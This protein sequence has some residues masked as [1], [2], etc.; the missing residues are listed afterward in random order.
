MSLEKRAIMDRLK[1]QGTTQPT[2][3]FIAM[4]MR[5]GHWVVKSQKK[6]KERQ[7]KEGEVGASRRRGQCG[8]HDSCLPLSTRVAGGVSQVSLSTSCLLGQTLPEACKGKEG[9]AHHCV[10]GPV[11]F[12]EEGSGS[13]GL[14]REMAPRRTA[15]RQL[16]GLIQVFDTPSIPNCWHF[17]AF[18][19][20]HL[21]SGSLADTDWTS[22]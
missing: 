11:T 22:A 14:N 3:P 8:R 12:E 20:P 15:G 10:A 16:L 2:S 6:G 19:L 1:I 9:L 5:G 4:E 13:L 21:S 18:G 17:K 7:V